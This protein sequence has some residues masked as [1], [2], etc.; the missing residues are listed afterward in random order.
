MHS[1][2]AVPSGFSSFGGGFRSESP[3]TIF[4]GSG[5]VSNEPL[6]PDELRWNVETLGAQ[7][8]SGVVSLLDVV[9]A[10]KTA[11]PPNWL[12]DH[13][14]GDDCTS[15]VFSM[16]NHQVLD[17]YTA[18]LHAWG[19]E[20]IIVPVIDDEI[21]SRGI[22]PIESV[23][24]T[25]FDIPKTI[26]QSNG[27]GFNF[28]ADNLRVRFPNGPISCFFE[29]LV[30]PMSPL[31]FAH[32]SFKDLGGNSAWSVGLIPEAQSNNANVLWDM[33]G[34]IGRHYSGHGGRLPTVRTSQ[35][36][37][38]T[39]CVDA[40][41]RLW[42]LCVNGKVVAREPIPASYFPA[43]LGLCGHNGSNFEIIPHVAVPPEVANQC[44]LASATESSGPVIWQVVHA[45]FGLF[46]AIFQFFA[47][48][49]ID[50][51][52][53]SISSGSAMMAAGLHT[54]QSTYLLL[55]KL[56]TASFPRLTSLQELLFL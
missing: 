9:A 2:S 15:I 53:D 37:L 41:Q 13:D 49:K 51:F 20:N 5:D 40:V 54:T 26:S 52:S 27:R 29:A 16:S 25:S 32:F 34:S 39:S 23:S 6:V 24:A 4:Y 55:K 48:F 44:K 12:A 47:V 8:E 28:S 50:N 19:A 31:K 35:G 14:F 56:T 38:L 17:T 42:F 22:I 11:M 36:D 33:Q 43:R 10:I 21:M 7:V 18:A 46:A 45:R 3:V 30:G 1:S